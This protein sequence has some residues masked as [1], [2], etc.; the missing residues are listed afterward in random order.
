MSQIESENNIEA[1]QIDVE[2]IISGKNPRLLNIIPR[3]LIR[4]LKRIIHQDEVNDFLAKNQDKFGL[5]FS[6][7]IID[8]FSV[9]YDVDGLDILP[10]DGRYIFAANH[11]LGGMDGIVFL[12]AVGQKFPNIKFP[13]NDILTYLG[14]LNNIFLPI[15]KHGGHSREAFQAI[16]DAYGSDS[17]ILM[18]PAG[19]VSRKQK[20]VIK[21]LEWKRSFV[22]KAIQHKRDIIPVYITGEN[23]NFFYN[24]SKWRSRLGIKIN[25][26]M[27]YLSDEFFKQAGKTLSLKFGKPIP[28]ET[29]TKEKSYEVWA[30]E[31]KEKVYNL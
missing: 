29:F 12:T 3:F 14:Q 31:I 20:G 19:L 5:D 6:Q 17:Q 30:D 4:Y 13:V 9:S 18:F 7:A 21:D 26:E 15:N 1:L 25:L 16:E 28:W 23:T 27:L 10:K 24:L 22:K 8:N 11:P 2:K